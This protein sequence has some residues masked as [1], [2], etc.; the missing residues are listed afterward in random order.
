[1]S[2]SLYKLVTSSHDANKYDR[3]SNLLLTPNQSAV[4]TQSNLDIEQDCDINLDA[5]FDNNGAVT[6]IVLMSE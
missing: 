3:L 5:I 1:M 6:N 4:P 2:F